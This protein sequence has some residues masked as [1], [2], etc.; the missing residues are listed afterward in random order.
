MQR[1]TCSTE[2]PINQPFAKRASAIRELYGNYTEPHEHDLHLIWVLLHFGRGEMIMLICRDSN[3]LFNHEYMLAKIYFCSRLGKT[4]KS[5]ALV[6]IK[7]IRENLDRGSVG[8]QFLSSQKILMCACF[9][10]YSS[11]S[12]VVHS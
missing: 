7:T 12:T 5:Y 9:F 3:L 2:S 11:G 8:H 1:S 10:S 4:K 6:Y